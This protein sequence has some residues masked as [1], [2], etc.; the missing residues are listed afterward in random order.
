[1]QVLNP[2][3]SETQRPHHNNTVLFCFGVFCSEGFLTVCRSEKRLIHYIFYAAFGFASVWGFGIASFRFAVVQTV[4]ISAV[5]FLFLQLQVSYLSVWCEMGQHTAWSGYLFL[6]FI[7]EGI[8]RE[9]SPCLRWFKSR[10]HSTTTRIPIRK[11]CY[12]VVML[13]IPLYRRFLYSFTSPKSQTN[14]NPASTS[15]W[16][17]P[18]VLAVAEWNCSS[19]ACAS[20]AKLLPKR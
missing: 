15:F 8:A 1:V 18:I 14:S 5:F 20:T 19:S 7:K 2:L 11:C 12:R 3:G 16:A 17:S 10:G 13:L 4:A 6:T 9:T